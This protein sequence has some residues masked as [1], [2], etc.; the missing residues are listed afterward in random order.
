MEL[1]D[2]IWNVFIKIWSILD[3]ISVVW[4]IA[5]IIIA[6]ACTR[7]PSFKQWMK[8]HIKTLPSRF[9]WQIGFPRIEPRRQQIND[10]MVIIKIRNTPRLIASILRESRWEWVWSEKEKKEICRKRIKKHWAI[11]PFDYYEYPSNE[12]SVDTS[13]LFAINHHNL[14]VQ[15][16]EVKERPASKKGGNPYTYVEI[17][18]KSYQVSELTSDDWLIR[19]THYE[20]V[21]I[22]NENKLLYFKLILWVFGK[23]RICGENRK[24]KNSLNELWKEWGK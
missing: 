11:Y 18:G 15:W 21:E 14:D 8:D 10:E 23:N 19:D 5:A 24:F 20:W 6:I 3:H 9:S 17:N 13:T 12:V 22:R 1:V 7:S 4:F 16:L 2:K